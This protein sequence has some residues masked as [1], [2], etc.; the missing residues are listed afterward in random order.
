M[1]K[2]TLEV[3]ECDKCGNEGTR[4][5]ITFPDGTKLLDRCEKHARAIE[6]LRDEEGNWVQNRGSKA[7]FHKSTL[8][9]IETA[10]RRSSPGTKAS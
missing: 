10:A 5:A 4:Y 6:K 7:T 9:D 2:K 1:V 8:E 3:Y